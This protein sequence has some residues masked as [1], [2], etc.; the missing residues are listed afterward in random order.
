MGPQPRRVKARRTNVK[1]ALE[2]VIVYAVVAIIALGI[3]GVVFGIR[4]AIT[5]G[6]VGCVFSNDPALCV[7]VKEGSL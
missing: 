3:I 7:A 6:D 4:L 2:N 5:G 1:A